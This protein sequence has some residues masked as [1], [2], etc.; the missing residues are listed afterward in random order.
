[1]NKKLFMLNNQ[2]PNLKIINKLD[3]RL[4]W[5]PAP[6]EIKHWVVDQELGSCYPLNLVSDTIVSQQANL[7]YNILIII[8]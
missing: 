6:L 7:K 4:D 8:L 5:L 1:M 2:G 3:I